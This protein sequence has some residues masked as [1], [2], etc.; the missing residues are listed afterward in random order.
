MSEKVAI[1]SPLHN[2]GATTVAALMAHSLAYSGK[3]TMLC[4]TAADSLLHTYFGIRDV[5]DPTRS[6]MQV[7]RL[8][9][10]GAITDSDI[11]KYAYKYAEHAYLMNMADASLDERSQRQILQYV[12]DR[13]DTDVVICD[14][15][16]DLN[17]MRTQDILDTSDCVFIV[18][19]PSMKYYER[20]RAWLE[21]PT[22]KTRKNVYIL[23]N[24]YNEVIAAIRTISTRLGVPTA[25]VCKVHYNPWLPHTSQLGALQTIMP[26]IKGYDPRVANLN[27]DLMEI[28][29]AL[30]STL[31]E[32]LKNAKLTGLGMNKRLFGSE[33]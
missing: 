5:N 21:D 17:D 2:S 16:D 20:T 30:Q 25:R 1:L 23:V 33:D 26:C 27:N 12:F 32:N 31:T 6:I 28:N 7:T 9:D 11:V 24:Y 3:S 4:Y 15:S 29:Q 18:I 22:L 19:Q 14:V 8:I 13:V 10:A